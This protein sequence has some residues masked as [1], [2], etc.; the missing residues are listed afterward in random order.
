M[1]MSPLWLVF[2]GLAVI[3]VCILYFKLHAFV[4]LMLAALVTGLLTT[5][6]QLA[7]FA[8]HSGLSADAAKALMSK[9]LATRLITAFGD[10]VGK[11]GILIAFASLIGS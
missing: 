1:P 9:S 3:L 4:S 10:S 8:Q 11:I 7:G 6:T 2:I 5:S